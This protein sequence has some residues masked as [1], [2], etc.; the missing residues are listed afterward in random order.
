MCVC[1]VCVFQAM[2]DDEVD[3]ATCFEGRPQ[4]ALSR[5]VPDLMCVFA[6]LLGLASGFGV[7]PSK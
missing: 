2:G 5:C 6:V 1:G 4:I 3:A 7:D